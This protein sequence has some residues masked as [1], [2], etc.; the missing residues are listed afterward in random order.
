MRT[1]Y[2]YLFFLMFSFHFPHPLSSKTEDVDFINRRGGRWFFPVPW[3]N[4][5]A[6]TELCCCAACSDHGIKRCDREPHRTDRIGNHPLDLAGACARR[7]IEKRIGRESDRQPTP[8]AETNRNASTHAL[9]TKAQSHDIAQISPPGSPRDGALE[10]SMNKR[11]RNLPGIVV[12]VEDGQRRLIATRALGPGASASIITEVPIVSAP[13]NIAPAYQAWSM[14]R[15]ILAD[16]RKFKWA[17]KAHFAATPQPWDTE[18]QAFAHEIESKYGVATQTVQLLYFAVAANHIA[19]W[20]EQGRLAGTGLF[21]TLCFTNHSCAPN[22]DV[23]PIPGRRG[24]AL[25]AIKAIAPGEEITW[26]YFSPTD[27]S[28]VAFTDRQR[29]IQDVFR[30]QCGCLRCQ[31]R[32]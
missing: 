15:E 9:G 2:I 12:A 5:S 26:N 17:R 24:T 4:L 13:A 21:D 18:D 16:A 11:N 31:R 29:L 27:F 23:T 20:D 3:P 22:A 25:R 6:N 10:I 1:T 32:P 19:F 8:S 7:A 30:F 14:V 28:R